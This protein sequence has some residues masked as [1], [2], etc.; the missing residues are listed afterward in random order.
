MGD[1]K[2][3]P[4]SQYKLMKGVAQNRLSPDACLY[5]FFAIASSSANFSRTLTMYG[6]SPLVQWP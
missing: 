1:A 2:F 5:G 3:S 4:I 6:D